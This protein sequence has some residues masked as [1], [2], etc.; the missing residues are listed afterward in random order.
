[1]DFAKYRMALLKQ[2]IKAG[3]QTFKNSLGVSPF[4]AFTE[5]RT[6]M[7]ASRQTCASEPMDLLVRRII[8]RA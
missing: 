7:P 3:G 1:M 5:W 8:S 2:Q 4:F 6:K